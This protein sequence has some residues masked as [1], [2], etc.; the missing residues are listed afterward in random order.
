MSAKE[1]APISERFFFLRTLPLIIA[2]SKW[3]LQ[4][5]EHTVSVIAKKKKRSSQE[6]QGLFL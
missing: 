5:K 2:A 1:D 4:E 6:Y 3:T